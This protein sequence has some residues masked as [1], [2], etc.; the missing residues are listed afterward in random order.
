MG[1]IANLIVLEQA[2]QRRVI[3]TLMDYLR[4][5]VPVSIATL[6]T[7]AMFLRLRS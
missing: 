4:V 6:A 3:V 2:R 5:G 1:S 7:N